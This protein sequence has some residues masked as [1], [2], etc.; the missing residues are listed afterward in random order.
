MKRCLAWSIVALACSVGTARPALAQQFGQIGSYSPPNVRSRPTVSPYLNLT[1]N[2]NQPAVNY[3]GIVQPQVNTQRNLQTLQGEINQLQPQFGIQGQDQGPNGEILLSTGHG[4]AFL[5]TGQF[6]QRFGGGRAGG[7]G[8]GGG[9]NG[10]AGFNTLQTGVG[11]GNGGGGQ[12]GVPGTAR[13]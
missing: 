2:T 12:I 7:R 5:N 11:G 1:L 4:V 9:N 10:G 3:Y 6:Y 13:R 8:A